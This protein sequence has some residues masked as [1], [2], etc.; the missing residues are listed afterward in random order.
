MKIVFGTFFVIGLATTAYHLSYFV[1]L[2]G[3]AWAACDEEASPGVQWQGCRKR[4]LIMGGL[5]FTDANLS[6]S[7]FSSS[8]L[9]TI[10]LNKANL[11]KANLTR[12][13]FEGA[14]ASNAN[15]E[16]I[17]GSRTNFSNGDYTGSSFLKAEISRATFEGAVLTDTDM[18]KAELSRV[19]FTGAD[20]SGVNFNF[21]SLARADLRETKFSDAISLKGTFLY[22]T[23]I[24]GVDLSKAEGLEMWQVEM[25]CGDD[26]TKLPAGFEKPAN[27]PCSAVY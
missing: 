10:T 26:K 23:R 17:S 2:S 13:S 14:N 11:Y 12:A 25:T 3:E 27:W 20:I 8:D 5:D 9:R 7:D 19:N 4:N 16:G 21:S 15:F 1:P 24:E 18:S 6:T 22:R